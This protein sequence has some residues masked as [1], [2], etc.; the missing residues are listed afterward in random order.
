MICLSKCKIL[1]CILVAASTG[2]PYTSKYDESALHE[3]SV[4]V[5]VRDSEVEMTHTKATDQSHR[6]S[7]NPPGKIIVR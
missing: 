7:A 4:G 2:T 3:A 1:V 5:G 6:I